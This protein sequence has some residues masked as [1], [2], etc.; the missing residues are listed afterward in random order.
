MST[1][2]KAPRSDREP[3]ES[4]AKHQAE[5]KEVKPTRCAAEVRRVVRPS[6]FLLS[7]WPAPPAVCLHSRVASAVTIMDMPALIRVVPFV[8]L[9]LLMKLSNMPGRWTLGKAHANGCGCL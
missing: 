4:A 6:A 2:K 3:K 5:P 8:L 7:E 9:R 1:A